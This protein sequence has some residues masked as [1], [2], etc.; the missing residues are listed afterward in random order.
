[1]ALGTSSQALAVNLD[2]GSDLKNYAEELDASDG[3]AL[4]S[5]SGN[6]LEAT[7]VLGFSLTQGDSKYIRLDLSNVAFDGPVQSSDFSEST[8]DAD[9][10]VAQQDPDEQWVVVE[11]NAAT[12]SEALNPETSDHLNEAENEWFGFD[13]G[14]TVLCETG[15]FPEIDVLDPEHWRVAT[16]TQT[17]QT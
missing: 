12:A 11:I 13:T 5:G 3:L 2:D 14:F 8:G 7:V 9:F 10:I 6:V 15:S 16:G 4:E 1:M 17:P